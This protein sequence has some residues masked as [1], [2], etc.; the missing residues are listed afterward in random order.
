ML[1]NILSAGRLFMASFQ[2]YIRTEWEAIGLYMK[3]IIVNYWL[4]F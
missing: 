2:G 1:Q 3:F 4:L